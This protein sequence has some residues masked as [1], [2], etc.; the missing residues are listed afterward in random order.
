MDS[1]SERSL[2]TTRLSSS[3][4]RNA[5]AQ[6]CGINVLQQ[7][8]IRCSAKYGIYLE[9]KLFNDHLAINE[10]TLDEIICAYIALMSA[11]KH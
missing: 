8:I 10:S 2:N 7:K 11:I 4:H 6:Q 3:L 9:F 1:Q 5:T